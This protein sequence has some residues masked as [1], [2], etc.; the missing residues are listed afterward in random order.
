MEEERKKVE[1]EVSELKVQVSELKVQIPSLVSEAGARAVEE[2][3]TSS[4]ME[5][6]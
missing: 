6:L 1:A 3:K 5:D 4:E 2:F